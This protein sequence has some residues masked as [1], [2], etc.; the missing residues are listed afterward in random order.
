MRIGYLKAFRVKSCS[1]SPASCAPPKGWY[2]AGLLRVLFVR[3]PKIFPNSFLLNPLTVGFAIPFAR[4]QAVPGQVQVLNVLSAVELALVPQL[5]GPT[6]QHL[7]AAAHQFCGN[8]HRALVALADST[9][10]RRLAVRRGRKIPFGD[11]AVMDI[12]KFMGP[13]ETN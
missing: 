12:D 7:V 13:F 1:H 10:N 3:S 2:I 4:W 11:L 5:L 8:L 6:S 9:V